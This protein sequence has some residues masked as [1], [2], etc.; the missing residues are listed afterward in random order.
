MGA[1]VSTAANM[2][3][4]LALAP[5]VFSRTYNCYTCGFENT[6][7][8][9]GSGDLP[10]LA[11]CPPDWTVNNSAIIDCE[12]SYYDG[13][14]GHCFTI[15]NTKDNTYKRGC[16]QI[17][18]LD[19]LRDG[20][21]DIDGGRKCYHSCSSDLCNDEFDLDE[22]GP[23]CYDCEN[24]EDVSESTRRCKARAGRKCYTTEILLPGGQSY[25]ERGCQS[26][27]KYNN[28]TVGCFDTQ[29]GSEC[30]KTCNGTDLCNDHTGIN[31]ELIPVVGSATTKA[32]SLC[33]LTTLFAFYN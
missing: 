29:S 11:N 14:D 2:K 22:V 5:V 30:F 3:V 20:C 23:E 32:V 6:T 7:D 18:E 24:C 8:D 12:D 33:L 25:Y 1:E 28:L 15:H 9:S 21:V 4:V 19:H 13:P 16:N 31:E 27:S 26:A 10:T 17:P